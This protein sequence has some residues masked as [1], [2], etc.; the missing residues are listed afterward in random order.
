MEARILQINFT[1]AEIGTADYDAAC[2]SFSEP[3]AAVTG[4]CWKVW[5]LNEAE[6]RAGGIYLF[7]DERALRA[8]ADGPIVAQIRSAP[9]VRDLEAR[10][11]AVMPEHSAVTRAPLAP[12]PAGV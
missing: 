7:D 8:Y 4:L 5:L 11:F 3:I 2:R 1:L 6:R 12:V 10:E 9:F